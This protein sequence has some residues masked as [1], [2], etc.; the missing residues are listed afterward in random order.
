MDVPRTKA[1]RENS[2]HKISAVRFR[3]FLRLAIFE[4]GPFDRREKN[5]IPRS[6]PLHPRPAVQ[7]EALLRQIGGLVAHLPRPLG[8]IAEVDMGQAGEPPAGRRSFRSEDGSRLGNQKNPRSAS[9]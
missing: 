9:P 2:L 5:Q 7:P 6:L 8:P 1:K 3:Q 4:G